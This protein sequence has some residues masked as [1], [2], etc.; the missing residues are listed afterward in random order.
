MSLII[1]NWCG[2]LGNNVLQIIRAI[3]YGFINNYNSIEFPKHSAFINNKIIINNLN[4]NKPIIKNSFFYLKELNMI[5][6]EP[7]IMK[8]YFK[9]YINPIFFIKSNEPINNENNLYIHIR[10]G[11]C[12][13]NPHSY[14][15]PPPFS[16][17]IKIIEDKTWH[18][19]F[20]V[21]ED[22]KNPC[23][24]LLKNKNYPNIEFIS[25]S[26]NNDLAILSQSEN[27]V[28]GFGTFGLLIYFLSNNI[29]KLYIPDY[30]YNE[31]PHG[32]GI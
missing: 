2:R 14:Y 13:K 7:F 21:Y 8:K 19:I 31:M 20:I 4:N 12:F 6:P 15:V 11:D 27:L 9:E 10:S 28:I 18:K 17:Y 26:L 16:Y 24:N 22:D 1:S 5:D 25:G 23:V 30:A 29:K 3:H 32:D